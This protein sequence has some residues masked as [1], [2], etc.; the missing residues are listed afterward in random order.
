MTRTLVFHIVHRKIMENTNKKP[1]L[2][3]L[4]EGICGKWILKT[5]FS[6]YNVFHKCEYFFFQS[7]F[8]SLFN[9]FQKIQ[10]QCSLCCSLPCFCVLLRSHYGRLQ[11]FSS[12]FRKSKEI[13]V[14]QP[15]FLCDYAGNYLL[16][17]WGVGRGGQWG[18]FILYRWDSV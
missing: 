11:C 7:V 17:R 18:V 2:I 4:F 16:A 3:I 10:E 14:L 6:Q 1:N 13:G 9:H 8:W 5:I 12:Y 15:I